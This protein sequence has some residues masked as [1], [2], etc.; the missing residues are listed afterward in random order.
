MLSTSATE[1]GGRQAMGNTV[2]DGV[3]DKGSIAALSADEIDRM[4]RHELVRLIRGAELPSI[5]PFAE[6]CLNAY[7]DDTLRRLARLA[8]RTCRNQGY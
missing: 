6:Q 3:L 7:E 5:R 8:R 2:G 1:E 4:G